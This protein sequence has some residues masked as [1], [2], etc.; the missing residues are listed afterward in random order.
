LVKLIVKKYLFNKKDKKEE[1]DI[2]PTLPE[3]T[4][5]GVGARILETNEEFENVIY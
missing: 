4:G 1:Q 3:Y 5:I 2:L